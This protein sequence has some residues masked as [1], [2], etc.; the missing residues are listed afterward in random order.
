MTRTVKGLTVDQF[1]SLMVSIGLKSYKAIRG[2]FELNKSFSHTLKCSI[3]KM[4]NAWSGWKTYITNYNCS[5]R[6]KTILLQKG[7]KGP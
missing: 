7:Y 3:A 1:L 2:K 4:S 6:K 5:N